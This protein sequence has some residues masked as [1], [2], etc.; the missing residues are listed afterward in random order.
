MVGFVAVIK[1]IYVGFKLNDFNFLRA[2]SLLKSFF[3]R[4]P[5][6]TPSVTNNICLTIEF[7]TQVQLF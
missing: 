1:L 3:K 7:T 2:K 4:S 6:E 5:S